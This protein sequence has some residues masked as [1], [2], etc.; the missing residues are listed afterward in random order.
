VEFAETRVSKPNLV[1]DTGFGLVDL[2]SEPGINLAGD[3]TKTLLEQIQQGQSKGFAI[4][5][6]GNGTAWL[7]SRL[8]LF[9][10]ILQNIYELKAIVF[11][12]T[13]DGIPDRF[14]GI[15]EPE[16]LRFAI[17][18]RCPWLESAFAEAYISTWQYN[19]GIKQIFG[20]IDQSNATNII[21]NFVQKVQSNTVDNV[22]STLSGEWT[23]LKGK[24]EHAEWMTVNRVE[25]ILGQDLDKLSC[26]TESDLRSRP[27]EE[28][29]RLILSSAGRYVAVV[30][31]DG[32]F[33]QR[34]MIDKN[35]VVMEIARRASY[36]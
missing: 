25:E 7:S 14:V 5:D 20:G 31:Q 15:T 3:S 1:V 28:Q 27:K 21:Y 30:D 16:R 18:K 19:K 36:A 32:R 22:D 9:T 33:Q 34:K 4:F 23:S 13:Q 6:L 11:V 17:A 2:R 8:F 35:S 10:I 29:I 24:W 12:Y 26:I